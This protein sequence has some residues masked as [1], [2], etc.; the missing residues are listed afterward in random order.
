MPNIADI[1]IVGQPCRVSQGEGSAVVTCNCKPD[2]PPFLIPSIHT[3]VMCH[4][5]KAVYKIVG[6][7]FHIEQQPQL[8][9][10]VAQVG[11]GNKTPVN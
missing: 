2:N 7:N 5:C 8:L 1:P 6:V 3:A 9:V 4:Q 10:A 11:F